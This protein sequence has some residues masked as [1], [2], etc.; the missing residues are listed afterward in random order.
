MKIKKT[1]IKNSLGYD[2][3]LFIY[4]DKE[5]F[6]YSIDT[7]LLANLTT[8][9]KKTKNVLEIGTNNAA[10]SIFLSQRSKLIT[11]DAL[12]IQEEACKLAKYNVDMNN[13]N[14]RIKVINDDFNN[15]WKIH[16]KNVGKKY[17]VI[18]CNPPFYRKETKIKKNISE[19]MLKATHE[20]S[21]T[22]DQIIKGSSKLIEQKGYLSLIIPPERIV[23]C[24]FSLRENK[25]EPKRVIMIH[26]RIN[27]KAI[28]TFIEARYQTGIGT[29]FE[30]NIYL[31]PEDMTKHEYLD[32][33]VKLYQPIKIK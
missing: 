26:P 13:L 9:T 29:H 18:I 31:H 17:D 33:V 21:I 1:W 5:M 24:F 16:N 27:Q 15:W 25:F 7:I 23:D 14:N 32:N 12:E 30:P 3:N 19:S 10:L 11:I 28:L 2:N 8:L 22:L 4:Q 6:N 20:V